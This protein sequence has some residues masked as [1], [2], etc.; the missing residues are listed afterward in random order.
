MESCIISSDL[1]DLED[2][3]PRNLGW[4]ELVKDGVY[5]GLD[6]SKESAGIAIFN[7]GEKYGYNA[8]LKSDK[9]RP[10]DEVLMRR[11][12]K[13]DIFEACGDIKKYDTIVV[14]DVF[15]GDNP[16]VARLLFALNTAIDELILDGLISCNK[17]LRVNNQQ[18][19]SWLYSVDVFGE[20]TG[21]KDKL[22]IDKCLELLGIED[23]GTGYQDRLDAMGMVLGYLLVGDDVAFE[24]YVRRVSFSDIVFDYQEDPELILM[25][26]P[27]G[28][29]H[30]YLH[31]KKANKSEIIKIMSEHVGEVVISS[32]TLVLGAF[33]HN[34]GL[35]IVEDGYLGFWISP[36]KL[37]KYI[38]SD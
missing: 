24:K 15:V 5:L 29:P 8:R 2:A 14:E 6:I 18:W 12:L 9:T 1:F 34:L 26:V 11:E 22:K 16:S 38:G 10:H 35:P 31:I 36:K 28:T 19:K 33:G 30:S 27:E 37:K 20:S 25:Q 7:N 21:L 32:N 13:N 3:E 23:S 17:F 4:K